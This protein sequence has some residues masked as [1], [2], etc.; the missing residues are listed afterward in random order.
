[1][2]EVKAEFKNVDPSDHEKLAEKDKK[3]SEI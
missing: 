1:M 2:A 3:I